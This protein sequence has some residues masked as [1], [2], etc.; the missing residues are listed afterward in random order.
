MSRAGYSE[1]ISDWA[2]ICWRGAVKQAICGRRGQAF[3]KEMLDALDA[4]PKKALIESD[5]ITDEGEV[6]AMGS[7]ALKRG[8]DVYNV[9]PTDRREVAETFGI[10]P[11]MAAEIAY[12]NDEGGW[13]ETPEQRW[14][15][16]REWVVAQ[17]KTANGDSDQ[18]STATPD[19]PLKTPPRGFEENER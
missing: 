18:R 7:V 3:L 9:D 19:L 1:D 4:M 14:T 17:L 10:A 11:A 6:C 2:L 8:I 12:E 16:M 5:L 13:R 15:R